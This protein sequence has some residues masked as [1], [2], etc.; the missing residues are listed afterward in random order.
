MLTKATMAWVIGGAKL[1]AGVAGG[2]VLVAVVG[3][4]AVGAAASF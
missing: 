1:G 3:A 2:F 4:L